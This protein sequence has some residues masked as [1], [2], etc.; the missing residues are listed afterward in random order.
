VDLVVGDERAASM[1]VYLNDGKGR[2]TSTFHIADKERTPYAIA[3]GDLNGDRTP[4][5]VLGYTSGPHSVFFNDG[6]G[7][8]FIEVVFGDK[9]GSAYGFALGDVNGDRL[10]DIALARSGAPNVLF[11]NRK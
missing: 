8:R 3:A 6:S 11:L 9:A 4:D 1:T 5:V 7:R 2:L 10:P